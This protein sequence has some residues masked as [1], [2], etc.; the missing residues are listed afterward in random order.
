MLHYYWRKSWESDDFLFLFFI[1]VGKL[2]FF[3]T[4][5][6]SF[7][8]FWE[9][10]TSF[11]NITYFFLRSLK[12][13]WINHH[14]SWKI[15]IFPISQKTYNHNSFGNSYLRSS[16]SNSSMIRIFYIGNHFFSKFHILLP[17]RLFNRFTN[18]SEDFI[19]FS[20]FYLQHFAFLVY[21]YKII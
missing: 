1:I 3:M 15:F 4:R 5:Y 7:F 14:N 17:L 9:R 13:F 2:Y 20:G 12:D 11:F 6:K 19:I 18:S 10:E 8:C 16:E 21:I